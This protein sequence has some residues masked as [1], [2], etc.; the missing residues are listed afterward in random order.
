[1]V[2]ALKYPKKSHR[3]VVRIPPNSIQLAEFIGIEFGDGGISNPWQFTISLNSI[4]DF[5]YSKYVSN[6]ILELFHL[7][8]MARKRPNQNTL[9][10]VCSSVT[11]VEFLI[12]KG[13]SQGNKITS[14]I[15]IPLWISRDPEYEKV[16]VRGLV[17]TDGCLYIHNHFIKGKLYKNLGLCFTSLSPNLVTSVSRILEKNGIKSYIKDEGSRIYLYSAKSVIKY[18]NTF[19][20]SNPRISNK[21]LEWRGRIVA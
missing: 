12:S 18:L 3:K 10:L 7:R 15:D 16:F 17:D 4:S 14:K 2:P 1:M 9:V 5:E 21:Y 19:G 6:L 13:I 11:V 8:I 20:T